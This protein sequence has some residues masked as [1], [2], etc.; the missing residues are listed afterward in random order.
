MDKNDEPL[1]V[2]VYL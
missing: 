2:I 1:S